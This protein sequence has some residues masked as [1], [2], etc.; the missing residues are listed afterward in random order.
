MASFRNFRWFCIKKAQLGFSSPKSAPIGEK[1][2]V[3]L[4][5][6]FKNSKCTISSTQLIVRKPSTFYRNENLCFEISRILHLIFKFS[7]LARRLPLVKN[8]PPSTLPSGRKMSIRNPDSFKKG[9]LVTKH[10]MSCIM[11][12][13]HWQRR[14]AGRIHPFI[15]EGTV[16]PCFWLIKCPYIKIPVGTVCMVFAGGS[17]GQM[18]NIWSYL[19]NQISK[20]SHGSFCNPTDILRQGGFEFSRT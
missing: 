5:S 15:Q 12:L 4:I 18:W 8:Q 1:S 3:P 9:S 2:A 6:V 7:H 16:N 17:Y 13:P 11:K 20:C 19:H 10:I 14:K